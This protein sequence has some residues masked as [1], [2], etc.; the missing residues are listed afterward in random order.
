MSQTSARP[1]SVRWI[2]IGAFVVWGLLFAI[3]YQYLP[4]L[5]YNWAFNLLRYHPDWA[6]WTLTALA[7]LLT[8]EEARRGVLTG[9]S[10]LSQR[11]GSLPA[12]PRDAAI[13]C[14][15]VVALWLVHE[16]VLHGNSALLQVLM[17]Q[18]P[19]KLYPEPGG[20]WVLR[21]MT[22]AALGLGQRAV[23]SVQLLHCAAGAAT[24]V[25]VVR[26]AR[27]ALPEARGAGAVAAFVFSGGLLAA[28]AG[29]FEI[30]AL[31][32]AASAAFLWLGLRYVR[33]TAG[34]AAPAIAAGLAGWLNP[35]CLFAL[36]GLFVLPRLAGRQFQ[37]VAWIALVPIVAYTVYVLAINPKDVPVLDVLARLWIGSEGWV[38]GPG[39]G[40]SL[41][42][43]VSLFSAAHLK[44]LANAA[45][46]LVP[47]ALPVLIGMA[48]RGR[49]RALASPEVRF[50]AAGAAG[51]LFASVA[52][53]PVW[54][55]FDWDLFGVTAL[56][57]AF[58]AAVLLAR[59][60]TATVRNHVVAAA[61]SLQLCFFGVPLIAIGQ[62]PTVDAGPFGPDHFHLR[63]AK[64]GVRAPK[65][66]RRWL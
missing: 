1:G 42:T 39:S 50:I 14:V 52:T 58:L 22:E 34:L 5:R 3:T 17:I 27:E 15:V 20:N 29:R 59:L 48:I 36:P 18:D 8:T 66:L 33:G 21:L 43:D 51:L 55:P 44:Y 57:L 62:G 31:A 41:G 65:A 40:R 2:S 56:W 12:R 46:L 37:A 4:S 30:H 6:A 38:R 45:F 64:T 24:V 10:W 61:V 25:F 7:L 19:V 9:A 54:G 60:E 47:A 23:P 16:R 49:S 13:F 63:L 28:I 53:R 11:L 32:M 26:A 35:L